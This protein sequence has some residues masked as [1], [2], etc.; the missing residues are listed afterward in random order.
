M[1]IEIQTVDYD[2]EVP[3]EILAGKTFRSVEQTEVYNDDHIV[4][5]TVDGE[6]LVLAHKQDCCESVYIEDIC[7]DL[8]DLVGF[9]I[10]LAEKVY[11]E[12]RGPI[13]DEQGDFRDEYEEGEE[14]Y[15]SD[16]S[17]TWTF[18][19]LSTIKGSVTIRWYGTSNGYYSESVEL[20]QLPGGRQGIESGRQDAQNKFNDALARSQQVHK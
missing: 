16:E 6:I 3:F 20:Y 8:G 18:Y 9:P 12:G 14:N 2:N 19:K 10:L 13:R 17:Y 5:E 11:S 4:F 7:G 1:S 15:E